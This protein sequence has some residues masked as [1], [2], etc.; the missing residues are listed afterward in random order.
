M[1]FIPDYDGY[2]GI[3]LVHKDDSLTKEFFEG[4]QTIDCEDGQYRPPSDPEN[5]CLH[6]LEKITSLR[7]IGINQILI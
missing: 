6:F 4:V 7:N 3:P 5:Y 2:Y 1:K